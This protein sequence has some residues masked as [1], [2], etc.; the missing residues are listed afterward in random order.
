LDE[1]LIVDGYNVI[2]AWPDLREIAA[3]SL[4]DARIRLIDILRDYQGYRGIKI[5]IVFDAHMTDSTIGYMEQYGELQVIYTKKGETADHYIERW[6]NKFGENN[7]TWVATSDF[8]EQTIVMSKGGI[9]M[10]A[11]ELQEEIQRL[12]KE[13]KENYTKGQEGGANSLGDR[14]N[15]EVLGKL[16]A[17]R[18]KR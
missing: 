2:N 3:Y 12:Y 14:I 18:R 9:R 13:R 8:L 6:V 4:E 16:E 17:L 1:Y 11:R 10:S 15:P 7:N 5:I